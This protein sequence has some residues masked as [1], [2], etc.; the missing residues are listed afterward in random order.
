MACSGYT[1]VWDLTARELVKLERGRGT[2]LRVTRGKL[3]LTFEHDTRDVVLAAG[4]VFTIDSDGLT[5]VEAQSDTTVCVM[6]KSL[7]AI[8]LKHDSV[9]FTTRASRWLRG[10][11]E[12]GLRRG[13]APYA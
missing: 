11:A 2:T 3:W 5:L 6:A 9:A 13:W 10:V 12:I 1:K 8:H 4:D 7:A